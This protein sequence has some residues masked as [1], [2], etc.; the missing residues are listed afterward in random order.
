MNLTMKSSPIHNATALA[1]LFALAGCS[2][3]SG[4]AT[5]P[6]SPFLLTA[7]IQDVMKS[8]VDPSA[9][10][11][12]DTVS[13]T[14]TK[15]GEQHDQPHTDEQWNQVRALA[16]TLTE[17]TNLLVMPGRRVVA[18]GKE[19]EDA[20]I[21]GIRSASEIQAAIDADRNSW[22]AYAHALHAAGE[23]A[24]HAVDARNAE[25]L[26]HAGEAID[27]AC[28]ACHLKYWYPGQVIPAL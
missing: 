8:E 12:W 3:H 11:L 26:L 18:E 5:Q 1:L 7:T 23:Q 28:E 10:A 2:E 27:A 25:Q 9:D 4:A 17:A 20:H 22:I 13:T 6:A 16:V 21:T 24:L 15:Q 14:I 19:V